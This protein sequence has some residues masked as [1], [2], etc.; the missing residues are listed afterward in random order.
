MKRHKDEAAL[1]KFVS[2]QDQ[3]ADYVRRTAE[4]IKS[5]YPAS[6]ATLLPKLRQIYRE[7]KRA[8]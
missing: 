3:T 5:E 1:L 7:K 6:A 4:W 2:R 8:E